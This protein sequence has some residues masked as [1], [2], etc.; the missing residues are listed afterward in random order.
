[1]REI[2]ASEVSRNFSAVL[3]SVEH[4]ETIV[5]TRAG[6][7]IAAITPAAA[8]N[9]SALNA[10]IKQWRGSG[11]LDES[12]SENIAAALAAASSESDRDAWSG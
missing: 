10:V 8:A 12:F 3:D 1:M 6:R 11:A 4:G 2:T 9:G 5:I 7:R